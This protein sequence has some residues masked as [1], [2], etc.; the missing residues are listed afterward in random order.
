MRIY[1]FGTSCHCKQQ[2]RKGRKKRDP[3]N[4]VGAPGDKSQ[5]Y[6]LGSISRLEIVA[7]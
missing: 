3:G 4:K 1:A 7:R 6:L 2:A 5:S